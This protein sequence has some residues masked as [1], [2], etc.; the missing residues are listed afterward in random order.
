M[1]CHIYVCASNTYRHK[2]AHWKTSAPG[3]APGHHEDENKL[4][5]KL[6]WYGHGS[7]DIRTPEFYSYGLLWALFKPGDICCLRYNAFWVTCF[8]YVVK[9]CHHQPRNCADTGVSTNLKP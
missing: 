7:M 1:F 6:N 2:S 4:S 5:V 8:T 9:L 3:P